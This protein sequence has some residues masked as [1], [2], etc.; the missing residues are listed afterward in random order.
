[1]KRRSFLSALGTAPALMA[2]RLPNSSARSPRKIIAGT[3]L[4]PFEVEHPG[5]ARR[6]TELGAIVD[7]MQEDSRRKYGRGIDIAMLQL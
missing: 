5:L 2:T 4:Q 7:D 3:V 6:L 1:M